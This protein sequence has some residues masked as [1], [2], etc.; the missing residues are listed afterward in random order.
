MKNQFFGDVNDY[1]KCGILRTFAKISIGVCWMLNPDKA[2][3]YLDH[4]AEW[5][6]YDPDLLCEL[7]RLVKSGGQAIMEKFESRQILPSAIF[8]NKFLPGQPQERKRYFEEMF[9]QFAKLDLIFFDPDIGLATNSFLRPGSLSSRHLYP[10]ELREASQKH[11]I[12][13]FQYLPHVPREK[14]IKKAVADIREC[15]TAPKICC[16]L[17]ERVVFILVAQKRH[18]NYFSR[19]SERIA[20]TWAGKIKSSWF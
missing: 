12:L 11:S 10:D 20:K 9:E 19:V 5:G 1:Y 6:R 15:T 13:L 18:V 14:F 3:R 7:K 4:Q 2:K 17:T 8:F 16:L